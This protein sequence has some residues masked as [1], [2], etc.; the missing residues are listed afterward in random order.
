M[1]PPIAGPTII[2]ICPAAEDAATARGSSRGGTSAGS[3]D[4]TVGCSKARATPTTNT[5]PRI[6]SRVIKPPAV[7]MVSRAEARPAAA[8]AAEMMR[9]RSWRAAQWP[10]TRT[11]RN[12]GGNCTGP[13]RPRSSGWPVRSYIC[14]PTATACMNIAMVVEKRATQ[15]WTNSRSRSNEADG[16]SVMG[17]GAA[18][19]VQTACRRKPDGG[20]GWLA[21]RSPKG[22]GWWRRGELKPWPPQCD[23][24]A[25][26][27]ELRPHRNGRDVGRRS[28][29]CQDCGGGAARLV[30]GAPSRYICASFCQHK[31]PPHARPAR[32]H[33]DRPAALYLA[34]HRRRDPVVA[35]RVQCGEHAERRGLDHRHVPVP[36]YR[37]GLAADPQ[38]AAQPGRHRYLARDPDLDHH[39]HSAGDRALRL[40][41]RVL[42][43]WRMRRPGPWWRTAWSSPSP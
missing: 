25:L 24:G 31:T 14:Q 3:S 30:P 34:A 33:S 17:L 19:A 21:S 39:F 10:A 4:A 28:A 18:F 27:T 38:R 20:W 26:P 11:S 42:T 7:P 2:P 23:C 29:G 32:R 40:S 36:N 41:L 16:G 5:V 8:C 15:N 13:T 35:D 37:A 9:R 12:G 1:R 6:H 22:E 43:S